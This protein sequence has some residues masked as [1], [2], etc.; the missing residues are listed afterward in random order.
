MNGGIPK[1]VIMQAENAPMAPQH[2]MA[3]MQ[4]SVIPVVV[5]SVAPAKSR[6]ILA[7]RTADKAIRLPTD[8]SIPPETMTIVIPIA[9]TAITE[10]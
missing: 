10:I 7:E 9:T 1:Y 3:M 4:A 5:A 8:R 6:M 2:K